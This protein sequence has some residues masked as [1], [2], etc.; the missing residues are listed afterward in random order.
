M[1]NPPQGRWPRLFAPDAQKEIEGEL[2][3]HL[4][5]RVRDYLAR[6]LD[7]QSARAAALARLGDLKTVQQE[8]T[9][10]LQ[11]EVRATRRRD[12]FDDLRQDLRFG[13]RGALRSP[14]FTLLAVL[15]LALGIGANAAVFGVVKSVLLD[16]L[17]FADAGQLVRIYGRTL[18]GT[19]ER[20]PISA[21]AFRDLSARQRSFTRVASFFHDTYDV[22]HPTEQGASV[23]EAALVG[24]GFFETLGVAP[25][26]GR[27]LTEADATSDAFVALISYATWQREFAGDQ[28][29]IGKG[30]RVDS[31]TYEV[32]G[33]LPR[34]FVG[35]MG[36]ADVFLALNLAASLRDPVRARKS[37]WLSM[38]GRMKP[39][40]TVEEAQRDLAAISNDLASEHP[41]S[42]A[43][44]SVSTV[45][46]RDAMVGDTR[47]PLL[48]LMASAAFV[49]VITCA[50][51]AGALLSRALSRR[52]EFAVRAALGASHGR[53]LRQMLTETAVLGIAGGFAGLVLAVLSLALLR[54]LD[55]A[56]LP[57][58]A[59]LSLDRGAVLIALSVSL[60]AGLVF[61]IVPALSM[62]RTSGEATLRSQGRGT[63]ESQ[64]S[65]R[66]RGALVAVQIA[67]SLS[68]LA[69][70]GL[71]V[72]SLL[73][74]TGAPLGFNPR[75]VLT[76]T[77]KGP[78]PARD[79]ARRQFFADL[80][81]RIA[82]L[83]G[84]QGVAHT[85]ELP[86]PA[87]GR[88]GL[89]IQGV[90]WENDAAQPFIAYSTVSDDYFRTLGIPLRQGR[91]FNASDRPD[92]TTAIVISEAMARRYWPDGN[93]IGARIRLGPA[94][95]GPWSEVIGIVG[96][97]RNDPARARPE[98]MAFGSSRQDPMRSTRTYVVR[99]AG[100]PVALVR[101]IERELAALDR[102]VPVTEARSFSAI[103]AAGFASRRLAVV[104]M[105]AFGALALLLASVGVYALFANLAAAREREFGVRVAL[106]SST[107]SLVSLVLR[108]GGVW[109][110]VG[111]AGGALGVL[112]VSRMLRNLLF[113]VSPLDPLTLAAAALTLLGCGAIALL[114]PVRRITRTDPLTAMRSE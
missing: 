19:L 7:E 42:D 81:S 61:G 62:R 20:S 109:M 21:G 10:L 98:P 3:F 47:T 103:I 18:D 4:E 54:N 92:G 87:L 58:Y 27:L 31:D 89:T 23:L 70:A 80:E 6:G 108:Q 67:I 100:N 33:V 35:P 48:V 60:C 90:V 107:R 13:I 84:V 30:L 93:A 28:A 59:E 73:E 11:A 83:P 104:L 16:S 71:L 96:D 34:S 75:N 26:K 86:L 32:V 101:P 9:E 12:W 95:A 55:L 24:P 114:S 17:P 43:G 88:N 113:E 91:T 51:L 74:I 36:E 63:T 99:A 110:L 82:T 53:L 29:V 112:V 41:D 105:T 85:N 94:S 5:E 2:R 68:L 52:K 37:H 57:A 111:L 1:H 69:G 97:V 40:V 8:C 50:N 72:R 66:M 79:A 46:L 56:V 38:V 76:V 49:L 44:I 78:I 102:N 39:V 22:T 15:T 106:G 45:T 65:R 64:R 77:M 25:L 14:S